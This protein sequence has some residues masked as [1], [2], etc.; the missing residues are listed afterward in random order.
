MHT[1]ITHVGVSIWEGFLSTTPSVGH[2]V[3]LPDTEDT[4]GTYYKVQQVVH[5][6]DIKSPWVQIVLYPKYDYATTT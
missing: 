6:P 5:H 1:R 3:V 2:V 4:V